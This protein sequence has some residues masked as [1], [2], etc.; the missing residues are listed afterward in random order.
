MLR[1]GRGSSTDV[2]RQCPDGMDV[3]SVNAPGAAAVRRNPSDY[4]GGRF[5]FAEFGRVWA[6][7]VRSGKRGGGRFA[8]AE[9]GRVWARVVRSGETNGLR[10][11]IDLE[12]NGSPDRPREENPESQPERTRARRVITVRI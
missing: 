4:S 12:G 7:V 8:F 10:I 11:S 3:A 1:G 6:R 9:F 2:N 5:A